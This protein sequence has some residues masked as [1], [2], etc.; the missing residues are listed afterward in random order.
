MTVVVVD[1]VVLE[2]SAAAAT[3]AADAAAD[4]DECRVEIL[5][6][7]KPRKRGSYD[8]SLSIGKKRK[9]EF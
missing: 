9:K 7:R 5:R 8:S 4:D 2:R 1:V 6:E 3:K